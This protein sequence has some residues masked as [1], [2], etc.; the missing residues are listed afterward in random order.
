MY[1]KELL[2]GIAPEDVDRIVRVEH[3]DPHSVLGAHPAAVRGQSGIIIRAF[4]PDAAAADLL[5]ASERLSMKTS[6]A[7]GLFWCFLPNASLPI[8]VLNYFH[9]PR[10]L[11]MGT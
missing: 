6:E 3:S 9:V 10:R 8:K 7:Q 11:H 1:S 5:V 2:L 4:H